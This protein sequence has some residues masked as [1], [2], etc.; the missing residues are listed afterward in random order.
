MSLGITP[1]FASDLANFLVERI[2]R[3]LI[4]QVD[5]IFGA[6]HPELEVVPTLAAQDRIVQIEQN[7]RWCHESSLPASQSLELL[8][9]LRRK[10]IDVPEPILFIQ[11]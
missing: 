11:H 10:R 7:G 6:L 9:Q 3:E 5:V 1:E 2:G 8:H 4:E